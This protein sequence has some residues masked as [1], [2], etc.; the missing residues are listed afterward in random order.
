MPGAIKAALLG[1]T[2]A[3]YPVLWVADLMAAAKPP[4]KYTAIK[5]GG[6][7]GYTL[8]WH[9]QGGGVHLQAPN[10][11]DHV[12]SHPSCGSSDQAE[13]W[14]LSVYSKFQDLTDIREMWRDVAKAR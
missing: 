9:V 2:R 8:L 6:Q 14:V 11:P 5:I 3:K 7:F 4:I 1:G 13:K 10:R 12:Q